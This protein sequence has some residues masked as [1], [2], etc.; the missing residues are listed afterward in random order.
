MGDLLRA[1]TGDDVIET[2]EAA[3]FWCDGILLKE[4]IDGV[5]NVACHDEPTTNHAEV[6]PDDHWGHE[7]LVGLRDDD[8]FDVLHEVQLEKYVKV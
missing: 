1:P 3:F 8:I 2:D 5:A 6:L 4:V 7:M